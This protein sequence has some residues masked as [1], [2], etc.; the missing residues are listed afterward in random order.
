MKIKHLFFAILAITLFSCSR[1][2]KTPTGMPYKIIKGKRQ[3]K[4]E[5]GQW[6][7]AHVNYT[8]ND[9]ILNNSFGRVPVY[10]R[11]DTSQFMKYSFT[12]ILLNCYEGDVVEF[13]LSIDTLKKFNQLAY[14]ETFKQGGF[15]NGKIE[16]LKVFKSMEEQEADYKKEI[17]AEKQREINEVKEYAA[18]K[19]W[20]AVYTANGVGVVI[21]NE[22][23]GMKV[24]SSTAVSVFY[25]GRLISNGKEFDS[26]IKNGKKEQPFVFNIN[27]G[28]VIPG[29]DEG[30]KLFSKG[31][32]GKLLIPAM[33]AYGM[34][35]SPP[36]IPQY[37]NLEFDVEIADV[38]KKDTGSNTD[39]TQLPSTKK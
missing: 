1:L 9:S 30:L 36:V 19:K 6:V 32:K 7:K 35:G 29:W 39:A 38:Q 13:K 14:N 27:E 4:L 17:E 26:N 33:L 23:N 10:F 24:D 21:E 37:A 16:Y 18:K 31:G 3:T 12:E 8:V 25:A 20:N 5:H 15:I 11:I 2:D 22:G 34:Q 28:M